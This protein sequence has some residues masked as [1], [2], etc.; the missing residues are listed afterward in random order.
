V[1][2]TL[3]LGNTVVGPRTI[4]YLFRAL[5]SDS[6]SALE[7]KADHTADDDERYQIY[8]RMDEYLYR[9]CMTYVHHHLL[10]GI[11]RPLALFRLSDRALSVQNARC[12]RLLRELLQESEEHTAEVIAY[13]ERAQPV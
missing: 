1:S 5:C 13:L 4:D 12:R 7:V 3:Y 10:K 6:Y 2:K 11:E 8:S 9:L